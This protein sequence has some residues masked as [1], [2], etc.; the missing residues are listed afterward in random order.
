M[1]QLSAFAI[2]VLPILCF[3]TSAM[4]GAFDYLAENACQLSIED[5]IKASHSDAADIGYGN[6][7]YVQAEQNTNVKGK[8]HFTSGS[9]KV[10]FSYNCDY[11]IVSGD[12]SHV[13]VQ[14]GAAT[15]SN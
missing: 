12:T 8:G 14:M 4:A 1:R 9:G 5:K 7:K 10:S 6:A 3:S 15:A 11:N 13:D 2:T